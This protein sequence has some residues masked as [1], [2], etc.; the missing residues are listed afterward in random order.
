MGAH[1]IGDGPLRRARRGAAPSRGTPAPGRSARSPSAA[2]RSRR[3]RLPRPARPPAWRCVPDAQLQRMLRIAVAGGRPAGR[4][5]CG[6]HR[7]V[8]ARC[9]SCATRSRPPPAASMAR[10]RLLVQRRSGGHCRSSSVSPAGAR[11]SRT[12]ATW[13]SSPEWLAAASASS[14]PSQLQPAAQ[15]RGRLERLVRRARERPARPAVPAAS[16]TLPSA[17]STAIAPRCLDSAKPD[18]TT[19][20]RT[21]LS[22]AGARLRQR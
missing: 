10:L 7:R 20:A 21:G 16:R 14:L 5:A 19:S 22:P 12:P 15:H 11:I 4:H 8:L 1:R 3:R 17:A 13:K 18:R 9:S 2:P 6:Q